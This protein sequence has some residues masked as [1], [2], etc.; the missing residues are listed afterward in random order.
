MKNRSYLPGFSFIGNNAQFYLKARILIPLASDGVS[1][2]EFAA[3]EEF[4]LGGM[5]GESVL[6]S[7][8]SKLT[9]I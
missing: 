3:V 4:E 9:S 5:K 8:M 7:F 2:G 6:Q 1:E